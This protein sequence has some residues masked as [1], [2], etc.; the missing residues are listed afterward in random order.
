MPLPTE[1]ANHVLKFFNS[2]NYSVK[3]E[4]LG[5]GQIDGSVYNITKEPNLI[6]EWNTALQQL[7]FYRKDDSVT[8]AGSYVYCKYTITTADGSSSS[9]GLIKARFNNVE[10]VSGDGTISFKY[11]ANEVIPLNLLQYANDDGDGPA[12]TLVT[13][14]NKP[15]FWVNADGVELPIYLSS[16]P[17]KDGLFKVV[18]ADRQGPCPGKDADKTCYGGNI[19]IQAKNVFNVFND[20]LNYNVYDADGKISGKV[21]TI[22]LVS[23]ATTTDDTRGGGGGGSFGAFSVIS[24]L[25]LVAYRRYKMK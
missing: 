25:G 21:G 2:T 24:L 9:S 22:K 8:Q 15:K 23:T 11:L 19:Y 16:T 1:D 12:S 3:A 14:P 7:V 5:I 13:K 18:K 17:S 4:A 6:C 10:P 20:T